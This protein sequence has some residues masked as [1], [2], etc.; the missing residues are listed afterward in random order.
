MTVAAAA[1]VAFL[2]IIATPIFRCHAAD[3]I[4]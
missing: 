4:R 2:F 3:A 1:D